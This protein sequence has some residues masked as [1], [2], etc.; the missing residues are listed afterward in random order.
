MTKFRIIESEDGDF[1]PQ[2]KA[3]FFYGWKYLARDAVWSSFMLKSLMETNNPFE[4]A[5]FETKEKAQSFIRDVIQKVERYYAAK[6][7]K[8]VQ[9]ATKIKVKRVFKE[10]E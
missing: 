8:R 7:E 6:E 4:A 10:A 3:G 2:T 1:Y 5:V 9:I